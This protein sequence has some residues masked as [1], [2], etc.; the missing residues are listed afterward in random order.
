MTKQTPAQLV[1]TAEN[2]LGT[3]LAKVLTGLRLPR[4][5]ELLTGSYRGY[6]VDVERVSIHDRKILFLCMVRSRD[7]TRQLN[8]TSDTRMY[9]PIGH[10]RFLD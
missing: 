8:S 3:L 9:R 10:I 4:R 5:A 6:I 1:A 7:D 2:Q